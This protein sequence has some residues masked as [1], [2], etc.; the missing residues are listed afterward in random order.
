MT[1]KA[2]ISWQCPLQFYL[3]GRGSCRR[4]LNEDSFDEIEFD[5][6]L[7]C[8]FT[9]PLDAKCTW[10]RLIIEGPGYDVNAGNLRGYTTE[11]CR[12]WSINTSPIRKVCCHQQWPMIKNPMPHVYLPALAKYHSN[13]ECLHAMYSRVLAEYYEFAVQFVGHLCLSNSPMLNQSINQSINEFL[14]RS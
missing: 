9:D 3:A 2:T 6:L 12:I 14:F 7:N 13:I 11:N 10:T 1:V 8:T 4:R 5:V